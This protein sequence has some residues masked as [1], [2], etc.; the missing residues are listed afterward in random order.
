MPR[1]Y[2]TRCGSRPHPASRGAGT[3]TA[4]FFLCAGCRDQ[5]FVC[6]HCDRGQIYCA[7]TCAEEARRQA[8]RMAGQR[9]QRTY[10]GRLSHAGR[11]RRHRARQK[12]VTHQG[13]PPL[14][15]DGVVSLAA[16]PLAAAVT[17]SQPAAATEVVKRSQCFSPGFRRCHWCGERCAPLLRN[18]F[19]RRR[20]RGSSHDRKRRKHYDHPS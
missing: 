18:E 14:S 5:V 9:Y 19:L 17:T 8:Q 2:S 15:R 3:A 20:Q 4:R 16:V 1:H 7:G 10:R 11:A 12:I 13:S 6:S